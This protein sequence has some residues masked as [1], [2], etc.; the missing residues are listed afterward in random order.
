MYYDAILSAHAEAVR[1][2]RVEELKAIERIELETGEYINS[3]YI[4]QRLSELEASK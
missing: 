2:A 3:G 1:E 4:E